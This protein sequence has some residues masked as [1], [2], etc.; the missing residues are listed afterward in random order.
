MI[1]LIQFTDNHKAASNYASY[2]DKLSKWFIKL[3]GCCPRY[4]EYQF[5]FADAP[6]LQK[7]L[8]EFYATVIRFCTRSIKIV[9]RTGKF[10]ILNLVSSSRSKIQLFGSY[11][12]FGPEILK[13]LK[14][15]ICAMLLVPDLCLSNMIYYGVR[16]VF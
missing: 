10:T 14:D 16:V 9:Q 6:G 7:A 5:L 15:H 3:E 8:C 1:F 13:M 4:A 2:F 11:V 12:T